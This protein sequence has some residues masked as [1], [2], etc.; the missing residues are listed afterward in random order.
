MFLWL[1]HDIPFTNH[2]PPFRGTAN[3]R[4]PLRRPAAHQSG[5]DGAHTPRAA[6]RR[7]G[8]TRVHRRR[9]E[10][11][12]HGAPGRSL[13][14]KWTRHDCRH[15]LPFPPGNAADVKMPVESSPSTRR[16]ALTPRS[17]TAVASPV[18]RLT[19][20]RSARRTDRRGDA[21]ATSPGIQLVRVLFSG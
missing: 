21:V 15:D 20:H 10:E 8:G 17:P 13:T 14:P 5:R 12:P 6:V 19:V 3:D 18:S 4:H 9:R 1:P 16:A 7:R 11:D 2:S